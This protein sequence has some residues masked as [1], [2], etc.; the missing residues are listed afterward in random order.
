MANQS[1]EGTVTIDHSVINV[2][3]AY[4]GGTCYSLF[5]LQGGTVEILNNSNVTLNSE[6]AEGT[7]I[8]TEGSSLDGISGIHAIKKI[9]ITGSTANISLNNNVKNPESA[10]TYGL[11]AENIDIQGSKVTIDCQNGGQAVGISSM[12][13]ST[14]YV[15]PDN[16]TSG[17]DIDN[18]EVEITAETGDFYYA[19]GI[20]TLY[21]VY[22]ASYPYLLTGAGY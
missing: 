19:A 1:E 13:D 22:I 5:G 3:S 9:A 20:S 10:I 11:F 14:Q 8:Y 18:S 21:D 7:T 6:I 12:G 16:A 17:V 4:S 15:T 2:T